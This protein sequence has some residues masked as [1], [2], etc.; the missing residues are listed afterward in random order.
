M[1]APAKGRSAHRSINLLDVMALIAAAYVGF[2]LGSYLCFFEGWADRSLGEW[3][4][5]VLRGAK[6][7]ALPIHAT[8][9]AMALR[10]PRP[11]LRWLAMRPGFAAGV[12][13][14]V[15]MLFQGAITL[16]DA[17]RWTEWDA[18]DPWREVSNRFAGILTRDATSE[19]TATAIAGTWAV[20]WLA[21]RWRRASDWVERAGR[22]PGAFWVAVPV[23][24]DA[25]K[26]FTR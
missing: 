23:V 12:A 17:I 6:G 10:G 2:P 16:A 24:S 1:T 9:T 5:M 25:I 18:I 15:A 8:V 22:F 26:I 11:P 13:L 21:G 19:A 4:I 7:I 3:A 14:I 20:L